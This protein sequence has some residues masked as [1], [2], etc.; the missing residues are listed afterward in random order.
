MKLFMPVT[1]LLGTN[2]FVLGIIYAATLPYASLVGVE[3][4]GMSPALFAT[5]MAVGSVLGTIVSVSF[6]FLSDKLR[7]RR[8]LVLITCLSGMIG[9]G[10]IFVW[11]TQWAFA[12]SLAIIMPVG[13]VCFS[14]CFAYL[15]VYYAARAPQR[16]DFMVTVMRTIF[17]LAW[18]V[19]PPAAGWLAAEYSIFNVY[20]VS[21]L[22]YAA[23]GLIFV[24]LV[25][26]KT[27]A[28]DAPP[29][30]PKVNGSAW[31]S[32]SMSS[33][34]I[35]GLV[36]LVIMTTA[37]RILSFTVPLFIVSNLG[38]TVTDVGFYA[39][40]TAAT[41]APFMMLWAF[42]ATRLTKETLLA[43]AGL[44]VTVFLLGASAVTDLTTFYWLLVLNGLGT[45]ALM[46]IN[47]SYVQ[48]AIKGRVGLSTSLMDVVAISANLL[49]ASAF[50][51]LTAGGEYRLTLLAGAVVA[52]IGASVMALGNL[53]NLGGIISPALE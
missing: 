44:V 31:S 52:L 35:A 48:D 26:D 6:G 24:L 3:T 27:T 43:A 18:I 51:I 39:S 12:I 17:T 14:Q 22:S 40:I 49:G 9:H 38:G 30:R 41:E 13:A 33:G 32:F 16:A 53:R 7:D 45:A 50:G 20:L 42:L 29:P 46:S 15:R 2:M 37:L 19:V 8:G 10:L 36:G 34:T 4:L 1:P 28:V 21:A 47:I 11:P 23:V 5:I 25:L